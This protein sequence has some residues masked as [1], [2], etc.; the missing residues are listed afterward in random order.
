MNY[1]TIEQFAKRTG[2]SPRTIR[3]A[4]KEGRLRFKHDSSGETTIPEDE[5]APLSKAQIQSFIWVI[6]RYKNDRCSKPDISMIE[7]LKQD[8]LNSAFK[9]LTFRKYIDSIDT[10]VSAQECFD[11]CRITQLGFEL[12]EGKRLPGSIIGKKLAEEG[13]KQAIT[14]FM[15]T[16]PSLEFVI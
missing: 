13:L 4:A 11:S 8:Q 14:A 2:L 12:V 5:I 3:K 1:L 7:K 9:Q 15:H 16:L 6:L 10:C